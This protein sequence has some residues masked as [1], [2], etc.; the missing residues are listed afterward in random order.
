MFDLIRKKAEELRSVSPDNPEFILWVELSNLC[1]WLYFDINLRGIKVTRK[2]IAEVLDGKIIEDCPMAVYGFVYGFKDIYFNMKAHISM[3]NSLTARML[4]EWC[5]DLFDPK[6]K[7]GNPVSVRRTSTRAIY[8][9]GHVPPHFHDMNRL[10]NELLSSCSRDHYA[11]NFIDRILDMYIGILEI[12]PYGE[13]TVTAAGLALAYGL[14]EEGLPLPNLVLSET[15]YNTLVAECME[16][17]D[18]GPLRDALQRSIYN[19]LDAVC[20][21]AIAAK[22][23]EEN[24]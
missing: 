11:G 1:Y 17:H 13:Y 15:E 7:D 6:D 16:H 22:E 19:R 5:Q 23:A 2:Q 3:K 24:E 10:Y 14:L 12:Y 9:W 8:E 21:A 20:Q 18:S 4:D